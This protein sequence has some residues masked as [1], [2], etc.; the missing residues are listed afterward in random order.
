MRNKSNT[1]FNLLNTMTKPDKKNPVMSIHDRILKKAAT[2]N[3]ETL[4]LRTDWKKPE[5]KRKNLIRLG[6]PYGQ[7]YAW[8]DRA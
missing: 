2:V 5:S 8:K 6:V 4:R 7:P 1:L 3:G